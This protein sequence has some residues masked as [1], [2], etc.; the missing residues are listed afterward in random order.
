MLLGHQPEAAITGRAELGFSGCAQSS[1]SRGARS[2]ANSEGASRPAFRRSLGS[3]DVMLCGAVPLGERALLPGQQPDAA[4]SGRGEHT[5]LP[6]RAAQSWA[7]AKQSHSER[8]LCFPASSPT[9]PSRAVRSSPIR[10]ARCASWPAA[11]SPT[12]RRGHCASAQSWVSRAVRSSPSP[13]RV[14]QNELWL[15]RSQIMLG[16]VCVIIRCKKQR[17]S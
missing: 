6:S 9:Q 7:C 12:R 16:V 11:G 14:K 15:F 17:V 1:P 2:Y 10:R 8:A 5:V 3:R 13:S 4:I